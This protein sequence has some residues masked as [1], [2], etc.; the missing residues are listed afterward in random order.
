MKKTINI[1]QFAM[2]I[3]K[4]D[5]QHARIIDILLT[6]KEH[7]YILLVFMNIILK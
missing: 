5:N 1:Y 4:I 3:C 7:Y 2:G 6:N